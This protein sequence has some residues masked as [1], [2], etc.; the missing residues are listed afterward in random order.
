MNQIK[1]IEVLGSDC[2][3]C[4]ELHQRTIEAVKQL[5][6]NIEVGYAND[7]KRIIEVGLMSSPVLIVNGKAVLAGQVP[8]L[9]KIKEIISS[10]DQAISS[11]STGGCS[12]G[13]SC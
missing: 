3:S 4:H 13:G 6:L 1:Q 2:P 8:S 5:G 7:I 11:S 12:C 10:C 9:D